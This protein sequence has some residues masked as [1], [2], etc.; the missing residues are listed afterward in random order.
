MRLVKF[1]RSVIFQQ[2]GF[3]T[4]LVSRDAGAKSGTHTTQ[5]HAIKWPWARVEPEALS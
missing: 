1:E 4:A 5:K 3:L 2:L